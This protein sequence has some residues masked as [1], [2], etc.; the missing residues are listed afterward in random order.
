MAF[1]DDFRALVD[2]HIYATRPG[3]C[4]FSWHYDAENDF[5]M[6]TRGQ[7]EYPPC[8]D[9]VNPWPLMETIPDERFVH[10]FLARRVKSSPSP[11][12]R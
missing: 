12:I 10:D 2:I 11:T 4:G 9:I 7:I 6:Q 3:S 5:I 1:G 8:K